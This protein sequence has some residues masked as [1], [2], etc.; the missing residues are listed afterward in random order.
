MKN[1]SS[2][3]KKYLIA[4]VLILVLAGGGYFGWKYW[5]TRQGSPEAQ[6]QQAEAE[7][8]QILTQLKKLMVLPEGDPV[9]FK[10]SNEDVMRKQQAFFKDTKNDDVLLVF[11]QSGKAIIYRPSTN[12]IVNVGPV[13]FDNTQTNGTS[14]TSAPKETINPA[15]TSTKK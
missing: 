6:A 9:L 13:N 15:A 8:A 5:Q 4:L 14:G 3:M 7:K 12:V 11:Q 2:S 10:V 1:K